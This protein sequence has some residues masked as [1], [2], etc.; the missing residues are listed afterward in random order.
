MGIL[1]NLP[2]ALAPGMGMNA[3]FAYSV[4]GF[5]GTGNISYEAAVTAVA[6]EGACFVVLSVSGLRYALIRWIPEPVRVATPAAIGAFLAHLGLQTAEGLGIVVSDIATAVTLGACPP[7]KRTPIVALTESCA[8]D[9]TTCVISDAYTCDVRGGVMTSPTTWV[10]ILGTIMILVLLSYRWNSAFVVSISFIT[11][12]SWFRNT[13]IT[14]FPD[15]PAGNERFEY[16]KQIVAVEGVSN[17]FAPFTSDLGQVGVAL[18][19]FL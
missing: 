5:R 19:T 4:V 10:G 15:T 7:D 11:F 18:F 16:F 12:I 6:I 1:A 14:Y 13:S 9:T 3:Y 2:V 8:A 17:V